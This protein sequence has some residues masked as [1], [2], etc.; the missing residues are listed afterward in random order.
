M[1]VRVRGSVASLVQLHQRP[2]S[3]RLVE[4]LV[5][6]RVEVVE[7]VRHNQGGTGS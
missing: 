2:V 4:D 3:L 7:P 1:L 5:H 6:R